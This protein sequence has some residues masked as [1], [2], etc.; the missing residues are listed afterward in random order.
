MHFSGRERGITGHTGGFKDLGNIL[1]FK[2]GGR[3]ISI[4]FFIFPTHIHIHI[5]HDSFAYIN[6]F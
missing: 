2:P 5:V 1:F 3:G 4:L 6:R